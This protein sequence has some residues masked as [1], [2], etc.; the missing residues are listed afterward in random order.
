[1]GG[2]FSVGG[3]EVGAGAGCDVV[4]AAVGG[5][6]VY[7]VWRRLR[8]TK[9]IKAIG[10]YLNGSYDGGEMPCR[11]LTGSRPHASCVTA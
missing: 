4:G 8:F 9:S 3:A 10:A 6:D 11:A 5:S 7:V 2:V 1:M